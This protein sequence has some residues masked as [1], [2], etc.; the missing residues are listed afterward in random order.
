MN[1]WGKQTSYEFQ[2][3]NYNVSWD[4]NVRAGYQGEERTF[5]G[6]NNYM[7]VRMTNKVSGVADS[8][9]GYIRG[10]GRNGMSLMEDNPMPHEFGHM[11]GLKDHY[12]YIEG[13]G[14]NPYL[15]E[16]GWD[17]NIMAAPAGKGLVEEKN[18][19]ILLSKPIQQYEQFIEMNKDVPWVKYMKRIFLINQNNKE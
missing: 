1:T 12:H 9:W 7:E 17:G 6:S 15:I 19:D 2:G 5:N 13:N 11:L 8:N 18:L 10:V 4:I 3:K 14:N 16:E